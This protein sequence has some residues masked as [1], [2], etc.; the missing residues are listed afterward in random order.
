MKIQFTIFTLA[1]LVAGC[2]CSTMQKMPLQPGEQIWFSTKERAA[3]FR[4]QSGINTEHTS[5]VVTIDEP[6]QLRFD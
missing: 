4:L 1:I 6:V 3:E 5:R 2:G